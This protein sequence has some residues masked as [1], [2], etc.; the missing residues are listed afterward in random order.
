M[1][2]PIV[3]GFIIRE[4]NNDSSWLE[5][6]FINLNKLYIQNV[7]LNSY[8]FCYKEKHECSTTELQQ[9]DEIVNFSKLLFCLSKIQKDKRY[10]ILARCSLQ[11]VYTLMFTI[12]DSV[13]NN[14]HMYAVDVINT[15]H[16]H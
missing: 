11:Y 13:Y 16:P 9:L 14:L 7:A 6:I 15:Y 4:R 3:H 1:Y 2:N 12:Q 5:E 8:D 10:Q